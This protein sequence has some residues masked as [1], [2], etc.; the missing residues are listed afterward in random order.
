MKPNYSELTTT[1]R[2]RFNIKDKKHGEAGPREPAR[3]QP[4]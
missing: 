1:L 4:D 2:P 3:N